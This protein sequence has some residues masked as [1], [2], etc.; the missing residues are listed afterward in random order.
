MTNESI[1]CFLIAIALEP[2]MPRGRGCR[3]GLGVLAGDTIRSAAG[4]PARL[5]AIASRASRRSIV[6]GGT[7]HP[8]SDAGRRVRQ[9]LARNA[10]HSNPRRLVQE[11]VAQAWS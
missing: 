8:R 4:P 11:Y 5:K 3:G 6:S 10:S 9:H 2:G 7:A 1:A